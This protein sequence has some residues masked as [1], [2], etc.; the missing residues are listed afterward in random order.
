MPRLPFEKIEFD[1]TE[2][3][4]AQ[5]A[6]DAGAPA[7]GEEQLRMTPK[8]LLKATVLPAPASVPPKVLEEPKTATPWLPFGSGAVPAAFVPMK[9]PCTTLLAA[10]R[11]TVIVLPLKKRL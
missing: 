5:R 2:L 3:F 7:G 8:L 11:S 10:L 6:S 1:R 9:L 4:V